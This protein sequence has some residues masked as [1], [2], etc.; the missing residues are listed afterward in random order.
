MDDPFLYGLLL[1]ILLLFLIL[2]S[3]FGSINP[4]QFE[5]DKKKQNYHIKI[6]SFIS[7][8]TV[9]FSIV[10]NLCYYI[11]LAI[12]IEL[13]SYDLMIYFQATS[14]LLYL[15]AFIIVVG[16]IIF[17][18]LILFPKTFGEYF[19]HQIINILA[20]PLL[21][22]YILLYPFLLLTLLFSRTPFKIFY[23]RDITLVRKLSFNKEDLNRLLADSQK[24]ISN[25]EELDAE[26]RLF[27]NALE[28]SEVRLREC[29]IPRTEIN[30]VE[31]NEIETEIQQKFIASGYSKILVYRDNIENIIGYI[32]SK[33]LFQ[34]H[35]ELKKHIKN[36]K[37][38]PESMPASKLLR[39]FIRAGQNIAV[40]VDEFGGTSGIVTT[41]DILE[42]IFGDI[43]DEHD[44]ENL[45][46]KK[47]SET[48]Y[49]FSGRLEID[50]LNEK[51][52]L[53]IPESEE[54]ETIAG[55]ILYH[56]E[57]LPRINDKITIDAF[58][59][60]ILKVTE[61]RVNLV[62]LEISAE[63]S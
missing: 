30:A 40:V 15:L 23:N 56:T 62:K 55:F 53:D 24:H 41:E 5:L 51:Y 28:F 61:T 49:I 6:L 2:K 12:F 60:N 34:D 46:E 58:N 16:L 52:D 47:L 4:L 27:Q 9:E 37:Y 8:K 20:V 63:Q 48:D 33:S 43:K 29:M 19:S 3:A 18:A 26:I 14:P 31:I 59:L 1:F 36:I 35:T 25:N 38:F 39:Y 17:P 32:K 7:E 54:Y 45:Y 13:L 44:A 21:L 10:I 57:N 22:I 50:Y 42:E 11:I